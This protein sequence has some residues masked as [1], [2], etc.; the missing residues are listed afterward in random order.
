MNNIEITQEAK[1]GEGLTAA[2]ALEALAEINYQGILF[3]NGTLTDLD[4][5]DPLY[6]IYQQIRK[7]LGLPSSTKKIGAKTIFNLEKK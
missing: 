4:V 5:N 3:E 6:Y 7:F 1:V 2:I